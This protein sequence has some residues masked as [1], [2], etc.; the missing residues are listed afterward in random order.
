MLDFGQ[1]RAESPPALKH[2]SD[3]KLPANLPD[4]LTHTGHV[5]YVS[6][7]YAARVVLVYVHG[8]SFI[9][10]HTRPT[11]I[12]PWNCRFCIYNHFLLCINYSVLYS[13]E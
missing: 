12:Y 1:H 13:T 11:G 4:V 8:I 10:I 6:R 7:W 5:V 2:Y 3:L 9:L